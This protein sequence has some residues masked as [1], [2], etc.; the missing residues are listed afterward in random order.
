L[1]V[2]D[3][4][5]KLEE[6][7]RMHLQNNRMDVKFFAKDLESDIWLQIAR[8]EDYRRH[9][10][11][12]LVVAGLL[13]FVPRRR[14]CAGVMIVQRSCIDEDLDLCRVCVRLDHKVGRKNRLCEN[15]VGEMVVENSLRSVFALRAD[16]VWVD[17]SIFI[18]LVSK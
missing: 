7:S 12:W 10:K 2:F 18:T 11:G 17:R 8:L 4:F 13:L 15:R 3:G 5:D 14:H 6:V 16:S 9:W 1:T